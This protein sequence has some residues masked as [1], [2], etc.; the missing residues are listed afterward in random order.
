MSSR[1]FCKQSDRAGRSGHMNRW[2]GTVCVRATWIT[3]PSCFSLFTA[4]SVSSAWERI[5]AGCVGVWVI[6]NAGTESG[7]RH[8]LSRRQCLWQQ[9]G[10][11]TPNAFSCTLVKTYNKNQTNAGKR[12]QIHSNTWRICCLGVKQFRTEAPKNPIKFRAL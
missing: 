5:S 4:L 9:C 3:H 10:K 11:E 7:E 12:R 1:Y 2:T 6:I 8:S